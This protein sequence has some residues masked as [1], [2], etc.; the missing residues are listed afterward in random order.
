MRKEHGRK[1]A[2]QAQAGKACA[3][4]V[5]GSFVLDQG[6]WR[7]DAL[8]AF[9]SLPRAEGGT[10]QV[11]PKQKTMTDGTTRL[12]EGLLAAAAA[13]ITGIFAKKTIGSLRPAE[14]RFDLQSVA[15]T[16]AA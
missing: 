1:K 15:A 4:L 3:V 14:L 6:S 8:A 2:Q 12:V 11:F 9:R 7:R 16:V 13:R 5:A 10:A